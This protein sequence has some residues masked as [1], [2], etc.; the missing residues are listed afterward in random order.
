MFVEY[1]LGGSLLEVSGDTI[2]L[3]RLSPVRKLHHNCLHTS[4]D[5]DI[6]LHYMANNGAMQPAFG[7]EQVAPYAP[8][9]PGGQHLNRDHQQRD[10]PVE[11]TVVVRGFPGD[12]TEREIMNFGRFL[13]G[14]RKCEAVIPESEDSED[15]IHA[16]IS[17]AGLYNAEYA[18]QSIHGCH[19]DLKTKLHTILLDGKGN[20]VAS[21]RQAHEPFFAYG[22]AMVMSQNVGSNGAAP[23]AAVPINSVISAPSDAV[24]AHMVA[25]GNSVMMSQQQPQSQNPPCNTLFI[26]NLTDGVDE[27]ELKE[28]FSTEPGFQQL[29]LAHT[30]KGISAFIEFENVETAVE[31]HKSKQGIVLKSSERGPIRV[32]FSKNPFGYRD[33]RANRQP[34]SPV[35]Q[36]LPAAYYSIGHPHPAAGYVGYDFMTK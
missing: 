6:M 13:P 27:D 23:M 32:Q 36:Y 8:I 33:P 16:K 20:H 21:R 26:G 17:F 2:L 24:N 22:P 15:E 12:V 28:V 14:F 1:S 35:A 31:C 19:F 30:K 25:L 18:M 10:A 4:P 3:L 9:S 5:S 11:Y 7:G 29:K 34:L